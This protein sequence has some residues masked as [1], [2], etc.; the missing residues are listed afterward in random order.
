MKFKDWLAA[1]VIAGCFLT[2]WFQGLGWMNIDKFI[3]GVLFGTGFTI[4]IQYHYRK[5]EPEQK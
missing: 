4:V 1:G 5:K 3:L 2:A